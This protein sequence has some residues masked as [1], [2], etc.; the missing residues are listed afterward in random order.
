MH[1][2]TAQHVVAG[3]EE[4]P[5]YAYFED[6]SRY[7]GKVIGTDPIADI[8]VIQIVWNET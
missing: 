8:A 6:G 4:E 7:I 1:I 3:F 2:V 5:F